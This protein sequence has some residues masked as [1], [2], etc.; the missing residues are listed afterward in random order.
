M[1]PLEVTLRHRIQNQEIIE[2]QQ[3]EYILEGKM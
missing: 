1:L 2:Q 3:T